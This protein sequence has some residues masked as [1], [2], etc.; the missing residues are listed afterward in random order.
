MK[1]ITTSGGL[2][3]RPNFHELITYLETDQPRKSLPTRVATTLRNL[4]QLTQLDGD[5]LTDLT[6]I[7]TRLHK[8]KLRTILLKEHATPTGLSMAEASAQT[9]ANDVFDWHYEEQPSRSDAPSA[10]LS[11]M[12]SPENFRINT[13]LRTREHSP[14]IS[15]FRAHI[16]EAE[17]SKK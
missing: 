14:L 17:M 6:D 8:D 4:P 10:S 13:A 2:R 12:S 16:D 15:P 11:H 5:T 1:N 9:E 3:L 7:E